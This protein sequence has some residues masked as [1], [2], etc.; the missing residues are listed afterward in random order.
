[1][2]P[3]LLSAR[4][5]GAEPIAHDSRPQPPRGAELRDLLEKVVVR[6]EKERQPLSKLVDVQPARDR[7]LHVRDRIG[8]GEGHFLYG[9]RAGFANVITAD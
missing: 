1:M 6:V 4:I 7:G 5:G 9:S 2:E 3:Q 8:E